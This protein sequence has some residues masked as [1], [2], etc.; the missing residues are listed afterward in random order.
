MA[1]LSTLQLADLCHLDP[2]LAGLRLPNAML[3]TE[4]LLRLVTSNVASDY[5]FHHGNA[6]VCQCLCCVDTMHHCHKT[7]LEYACS[8]TIRIKSP[9]MIMR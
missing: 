1:H 6:V 4:C 8:H 5:A 9:A 7:M 2:A 3:A